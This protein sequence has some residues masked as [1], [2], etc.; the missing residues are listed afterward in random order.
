[1]RL[2]GLSDEYGSWNTI[3]ASGRAPACRELRAPVRRPP[4][5]MRPASGS[6]RPTTRRPSVDLPLPLSPT[7]AKISPRRDLDRHVVDRV[8]ARAAAE[9]TAAHRESLAHRNATADAAALR[10]G[11]MARSA[12]ARIAHRAGRTRAHAGPDA[13]SAR[14]R[15][16]R[17][18]GG[19]IST[20]QRS[21]ARGQRGWKRQP[22]GGSRE[23]GH[24]AADRAQ[25]R[26]AAERNHAFDQAL[27][28]R[29]L[30]LA[31]RSARRGRTRPSGPRTSRRR[32]RRARRPAR[33]R[34]SRR[35]CP[36]RSGAVSPG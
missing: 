6:L 9:R 16:R 31:R 2:R 8:H 21:V 13:S 22:A 28:V 1:M 24:F 29:M 15:R 23:V 11:R 17:G 10:A 12:A 30:R 34:A 27:R 33:S 5:V 32:D 19:G 25:R 35:S 3:C 26:V 7:S 18:S 14:S 4:I 36:S 20:R